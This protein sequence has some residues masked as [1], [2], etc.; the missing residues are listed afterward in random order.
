MAGKKSF[1]DGGLSDIKMAHRWAIE[2]LFETVEELSE[3]TVIVD[4]DARV[5]WINDRYA[6]RFGFSDAAAAIGLP[7]EEVIPGSLMREIVHSGRPM[8]LDIMKTKKEP[9]VVMRL[10]IRG[11]NGEVIGAIGFALYEELKSLSP[12]VSAFSQ[13]QREL[14][15]VRKALAKERKARYSFSHLLGECDA[16]L[17]MKAHARRAA[18]LDSP[19]LLLGETGTGKELLAHAIHGASPRAHMP[20]VSVNMGAIPESLLEAEFFGAAPGAYTGADRNGREG[21]LQLADG[22]TLFLDEIGDLPLPLQGKLLRV[23]QEKEFEPLGSNQVR[24]VDI[25]IIA[26]T[27]ADLPALV[28]ERR[29]RADLYYRLNVLPIVL[30]PLRERVEDIPVLCSKFIEQ[31]GA[32]MKIRCRGVNKGALALLQRYPW[33]GNVRELRNLLERALIMCESPVLQAQDIAPLLPAAT[34]P[35]PTSYA[36]A[37]AAFDAELLRSALAATGNS[38]ARAAARLGIGRSTFYKKLVQYNMVSR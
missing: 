26:A 7:V 37:M 6:E 20:L 31:I 34:P 38:V 23:L 24:R 18:V 33:P 17:D 12:L 21:K 2:T 4:A 13:M 1:L 15:S 25:R 3:G 22:G 9:L 8:L 29:F 19:I 14:C 5:V 30:P 16:V 27:A 35:A 32:Q 11:E 36:D 28:A 10:P